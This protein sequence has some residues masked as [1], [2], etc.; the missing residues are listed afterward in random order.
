MNLTPRSDVQV[1]LRA[2]AGRPSPDRRHWV[3]RPDDLLVLDFELVSLVVHPGEGETPA[4]LAKSDAGPAYLI[5]TLPPQHLAEIAYF[6]TVLP[7]YPVANGLPDDP[8]KTS[9]IEPPDPAPIQA[10]VSGWSRLVFRVPDDRLPIDWN[11]ESLLLAM[12][13][14]E[15]SVP[16]NALPPVPKRAAASR[17]LGVLLETA[18]LGKFAAASAVDATRIQTVGVQRVASARRADAS[19]IAA[20][21]ARRQLRI[22]ARALGITEATGSAT[23]GLHDALVASIADAGTKLLLRPE[24]RPP[25]RTETSLEI[26]YELF[27]SPHRSAAWLHALAPVTSPQGGHT[28]LWHT[29]L[30]ARQPDGTGAEGAPDTRTVRAVWTTAGFAPS[31]PAW[32]KPVPK[33]GHENLPYRMSMDA[34]DRHNVVHLSS[35]FRLQHPL[36]RTRY[37]EPDPIDV[38]LLALSSLGAWF[39]SRGVWDVLPLG[40]SVEEWRHRATLG[41]DH[42][43]RIVYR[44]R[45]FPWGHRA[46]VVKVTERQFHPK[47]AGNPAYLRQR[48]FLVVK[49]PQRTYGHTGLVYDGPIAEQLGEQIDLMLPFQTVRIT[50]LVS[51][52]LDP[53]E[54]D[55]IGG[56]ARAVSGRTSVGSRSSSTLSAPTSRARTP[57]SRCRSSS[58]ARRRPTSRTLRPSSPTTS[59][60]GLRTP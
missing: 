8:D 54:K 33:P 4:R 51:P 39:N 12:R 5:V 27:L 57:I 15:L 37:Y 40:L 47:V 9:G 45:L 43:V 52:L 30:G 19:I 58:S 25:S 14:F 32:G 56:E 60:R 36:H 53:P 34:F 3:I 55:Q 41:R 18:T 22:G 7:A 24:P 29:R 17:A 26:P 46:S 50:T 11:L 21:R 23:L 10:V 59:I 13:S 44:G 42:Y 28:E 48:M 2:F 38:K 49:E 31:T 6:T 16:A 35:N 1:R 20:S